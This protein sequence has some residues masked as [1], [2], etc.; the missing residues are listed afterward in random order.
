[1]MAPATRIEFPGQ[2]GASSVRAKSC[3]PGIFALP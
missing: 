3:M 1:L 2:R